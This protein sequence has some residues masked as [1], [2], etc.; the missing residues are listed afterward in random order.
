MDTVPHPDRLL[1]L[2]GKV[3]LVT[4]GGSG[5]GSGIARRFAQA[6]ADV[7]VNFQSNRAG[8]AAVVS[9]VKARGRRALAVQADVTQK[10]EVERMIERTL[11]TFGQLD[12][13]INNAGCYPLASL[14][15][16]EEDEW[17]RVLAANLRS[18]FLCTQSAAKIMVEL[19]K[20][21]A[22]VNIASI[23]GENPAPGHSHY[24]AA[25]GGVLIH[26]VA[27]ARE[28]GP[29]G[30]R[31]NAVSPGLI[32]R[33][34]IEQ[35]WPEGVERWRNAAPLARLGWPDDVADACLFLSSPAARWITGI[36]LRVDGGIMTHQT[37]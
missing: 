29:H 20:G 18:V 22:I 15:E 31:V 10:V 14:L 26:T 11:E 32:W 7:V 25:K 8:A 4:G 9:A 37:Y 13:L 5:L 30:I 36:N 28:L 16:M 2:A 24:G 1:N 35:E 33:P 6:A 19:G 27:A 3:V 34:G 17:Q 12:I 23:E 21:G